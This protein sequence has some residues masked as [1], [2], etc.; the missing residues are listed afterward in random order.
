[1]KT[2]PAYCPICGGELTVTR[3]HCLECD[4]QIDGRFRL[5]PFARMSPEQLKFIET[6]IR[7][8]GKL[9]RMESEL[10]LSYPTIRSRLHEII[11]LFGYEPGSVE[12]STGTSPEKRQTILEALERG[13]IT[14]QEA[15][16]LLQE[17][18][19]S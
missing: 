16:R 8:E 7:C 1:M 11:R 18:A 5:E 9:N 10:N 4:S 17:G 12:E 3:V 2:L 19:E 6:F 15:V 14:P 13:E